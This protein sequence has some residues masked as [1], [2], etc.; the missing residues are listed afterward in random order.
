[1]GEWKEKLLGEIISVKGGF[2]YKGEFI[3]TG[4]S[5]LLG[6]GCVS[7]K[8]K[9]LNNKLGIKEINN[10]VYNKTWNMITIVMQENPSNEPELFTKRT[11]CKVYFN[12]T[13]ISDRVTNTTDYL[14]TT[15]QSLSTVMKKNISNL[16]LNPLNVI[17][18]NDDFICL[19]DMAKFKNAEDALF[20]VQKWMSSRI[21]VDFLGVW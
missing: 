9:N 3:G 11:N 14:N 17:K 15:E 2:S 20:V 6:M 1:M 5:I 13:L 8:E 10:K 19:T 4:T 7:N 18:E 16:H 12:G 21:A